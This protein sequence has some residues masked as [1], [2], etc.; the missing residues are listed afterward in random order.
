VIH[1][2]MISFCSWYR[3][4]S[5]SFYFLHFTRLRKVWVYIIS[6]LQP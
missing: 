4:I 5:N 2:D 6:S 3:S 1:E